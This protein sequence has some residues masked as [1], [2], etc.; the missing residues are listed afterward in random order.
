[1]IGKWNLRILFHLRLSLPVF[2]FGFDS[3]SDATGVVLAKDAKKV[4]DVAN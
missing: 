2:A 4:S 3:A 1:M